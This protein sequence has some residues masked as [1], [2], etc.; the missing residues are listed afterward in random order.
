MRGTIALT[1]HLGSD[2]F[3]HVEAGE[4]GRLTVRAP[5]DFAGRPGDAI[6]LRFDTSRLHRFDT[7]GKVL[8]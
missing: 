1:E 4:A 6:A 8:V 3:L 5:G 2:S 7:K